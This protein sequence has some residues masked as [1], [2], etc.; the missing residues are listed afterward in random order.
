M[1]YSYTLETVEALPCGIL[2]CIDPTK[3]MVNS[4]L[5]HLF[6]LYRKNKKFLDNQILTLS[7]SSFD[8]DPWHT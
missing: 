2:P 4:D 7:L 5:K 3:M 1:C 6:K 8:F